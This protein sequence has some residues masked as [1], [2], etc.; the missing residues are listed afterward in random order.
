M[1]AVAD[2]ACTDSAVEIE[3]EMISKF[4]FNIAP[5]FLDSLVVIEGFINTGS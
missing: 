4:S 5:V 1:N 3:E 2:V